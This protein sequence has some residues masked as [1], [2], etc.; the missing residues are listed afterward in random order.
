[1][2]EGQEDSGQQVIFPCDLPTWSDLKL[3]L[4]GLKTVKTSDDLVSALDHVYEVA[5]SRQKVPKRGKHS[6]RAR[7]RKPPKRERDSHVSGLA[8]FLQNVLD[9]RERRDFFGKTLP[10]IADRALE[11]ET[12]KPADGLNVSQRQRGGLVVLQRRFVASVVAHAFLCT[13]P[14]GRGRSAALNQIN[15]TNFFNV[16]HVG[17]RRETQTAKLRCILH[18]FERLAED[19]DGPPGCI[20][21]TRKVLSE[22]HLPSWDTWRSCDKQL[23]PITV[24]H[25]G[26]I[27]DSGSHT[28]QVDFANKFIGG[29]VLTQGR[30]Q[31]EIRFSICPELI[32]S[33][34]FMEKMD[35]NEAIQI[36]GFE[37]FSHYTGYGWDLGYGGDCK[38]QSKVNPDGNIETALCA[39]DAIPYK[40]RKDEEYKQDNLLRDLNKAYVGFS[41][42]V[43]ERPPAIGPDRQDKLEIDQSSSWSDDD[44][45]TA[46]G[47][48]EEEH[49]IEAM[50]SVWEDLPF[51]N[52]DD[53]YGIERVTIATDW[54]IDD[55]TAA[56]PSGSPITRLHPKRR[57]ERAF[58]PSS[59][60][61]GSSEYFDA[62]ENIEL[63]SPRGSIEEENIHFRHHM[64]QSFASSLAKNLLHESAMTAA[65][66]MEGVQNFEVQE[67]SHV[68]TKP[69]P[70][71]LQ[72]IAESP[73]REAVDVARAFGEGN[74]KVI[75]LLDSYAASVVNTAFL[76]GR[77]LSQTDTAE[78][79]QITTIE[80][81]SSKA[82]TLNNSIELGTSSF[83]FAKGSL[84]RPTPQIDESLQYESIATRIVGKILDEV[85][86]CVTAP[87]EEVKITPHDINKDEE[88]RCTTTGQSNGEDV[89]YTDNEYASSDQTV[90][91]MEDTIGDIVGEISIAVP[92]SSAS[93]SV[94]DT[95]PPSPATPSQIRAAQSAKLDHGELASKLST[96]MFSAET[97][98]QS[99]AADT[100]SDERRAS[101]CGI[102][103]FAEDMSWSIMCEAT[104]KASQVSDS[105]RSSVCNTSST[106]E[107]KRTSITEEFFQYLAAQ[108]LK[109]EGRL[110]RRGSGVA[111]ACSS[112]RSSACSAMEEFYQAL[113]GKDYI[114]EKRRGSKASDTKEN[115]LL[116]CPESFSTSALNE[117]SKHARAGRRSEPHISVE[118]AMFGVTSVSRPRSSSLKEHTSRDEDSSQAHN[119]PNSPSKNGLSAGGSPHRV[120]RFAS[121]LAGDII[122]NSLSSLP[123]KSGEGGM[124][125]QGRGVTDKRSTFRNISCTSDTVVT[126]TSTLTEAGISTKMTSSR[127]GS[128]PSISED[129]LPGRRGKRQSLPCT[130]SDS[131]VDTLAPD[132]P[133]GCLLMS[134]NSITASY[135]KIAE[136]MS[137]DIINAVA[138]H[139]VE[140]EVT[141]Q[142]AAEHIAH[143]L[144]SSILQDALGSVYEGVT[145]DS[146]VLDLGN[147][148]E[149]YAENVVQE[150]LENVL[151]RPKIAVDLYD[152]SPTTDSSISIISSS[153]LPSQQ[154]SDSFCEV[155]HDDLNLV[156]SLGRRCPSC[157]SSSSSISVISNGEV[158]ATHHIER[159]SEALVEDILN[160]AKKEAFS[161]EKST[162][163]ENF[164]EQVV[165]GIIGSVLEGLQ[166]KFHGGSLAFD[167]KSIPSSTSSFDVLHERDS[168]SSSSRISSS[169]VERCTSSDDSEEETTVATGP[170]GVDD[171]M[172]FSTSSVEI[173]HDLSPS[174]DVST[175]TKQGLLQRQVYAGMGD[176]VLS[177]AS[178]FDILGNTPTPE[179]QKFPFKSVGGIGMYEHGS[180]PSSSSI[181]VVSPEECTRAELGSI[182]AKTTS[183]EE[184]STVL[185]SN[186]VQSAVGRFVTNVM[187]ESMISSTGSIEILSSPSIEELTEDPGPGLKMLSSVFRV[188]TDRFASTE[189]EYSSAS[190][191]VLDTVSESGMENSSLSNLAEC[192]T[193]DVMVSAFE[194]TSHM[195]ASKWSLGKQHEVSSSLTPD[196]GGPCDDGQ[197]MPAM[198]GGEISRTVP[199]LST[200]A[201]QETSKLSTRYEDESGHDSTSQP[202][203]TTSNTEAGDETSSISSD[204][205]STWYPL[206]D[207]NLTSDLQ[208]EADHSTQNVSN[209]EMFA[210]CMACAIVTTAFCAVGDPHMPENRHTDSPLE[211]S[212][213]SI[214]GAQDNLGQFE[215]QS[216]GKELLQSRKEAVMF[217]PYLSQIPPGVDHFSSESIPSEDIDLLQTS[218][219]SQSLPSMNSFCENVATDILNRA[220]DSVQRQAGTTAGGSRPI[221]TGNW[222]C[223]A[224]GGDPQMKA[225][226][227]W[228]AAS[229][230]DAPE[231][232]YY[233]FRNKDVE[234]LEEVCEQLRGRGWLVA[235]LCQAVQEYAET[236]RPLVSKKMQDTAPAFEDLFSFLMEK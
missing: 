32:A 195:R 170:F 34:L 184:L 167:S 17:G 163:V 75:S 77:T 156:G 60:E 183:V 189:S 91:E 136:E 100:P 200:L 53:E 70:L 187:S 182:T 88:E 225:M 120:N 102:N 236:T 210:D 105:R 134:R 10:C 73:I 29:G 22:D 27:E 208:T 118:M 204:E 63:T 41:L 38:D 48:F 87:P 49:D 234:Q 114:E 138:E 92:I 31:E 180:S 145:K 116:L 147:T 57:Q 207:I 130:F 169:S 72:P 158:T 42:P 62:M 171:R 215:V 113:T 202:Q 99:D 79:E 128:M 1:M 83:E 201:G 178:S 84:I 219:R 104:Y 142:H 155:A 231:L 122:N 161:G 43:D 5:H 4:Q 107:S 203:E 149:K 13:F 220:M 55:I 7:G 152:E 150:V 115:V 190:I 44:F 36:E 23:C 40:R 117:G 111:S 135:E 148:V 33:I 119:F 21:F 192:L 94:P 96:T 110:S 95:P 35:A 157:V 191:A 18:Y 123:E 179:D 199:S 25:Q 172:Q 125:P 8:W 108:N 50:G 144:S 24:L 198:F 213:F 12:L 90:R 121:D 15:F 45:H 228:M 160:I 174:S 101:V 173:A 229:H 66:V 230:A 205:C 65:S 139:L 218:Q 16:I 162:S 197:F 185:A 168:R 235:D 132:V 80:E 141:T 93:A 137:K 30:V 61:S 166:P 143:K 109:L 112:R 20:S 159:Y 177:S 193:Q 67:P 176:S 153:E 226:L 186:I 227:Q 146:P 188:D 133:E 224:F 56:G 89:T 127:R 82:F 51:N 14:K 181:G 39:I 106:S 52:D 81:D 98:D 19:P 68:T 54:C 71:R 221:A 11:L 140:Q 216:Q 164:S 85:S 26:G 103:H 222:G 86:V 74:R 76:E 64:V 175:P 3:L 2:A 9:E 47:S 233:T 232:I 126:R 151:S 97:E 223:G 6:R 69:Q 196:L 58:S 46:F 212:N 129:P 131:L 217:E 28:L 59:V 209:L 194:E 214:V 37:Q 165:T 124:T 154:S 211:G 78:A 206:E